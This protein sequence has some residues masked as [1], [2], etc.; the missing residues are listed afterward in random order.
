[1]DHLKTALSGAL[2]GVFTALMSLSFAVFAQPTQAQSY[3]LPMSPQVNDFAGML[4]DDTERV[5]ASQLLDLRRQTGIQMTVVTLSR[6]AMFAPDQT[7]EEFAKGLFNQW[8]IGD[9]TRNDG[10]LFLVLRSDREVRI[11]LGHGFQTEW[12]RAAAK[13][14]DDHVL[15]AFR[16]DNY[17]EGISGGVTA[18]INTIALPFSEGAE[19]PS[20]GWG[21][22]IAA[23][24]VGAPIALVMGLGALADKFRRCPQCGERGKLIVEKRTIKAATRNTTGKGEKTT[25]CSAC[26][27]HDI[28][29]Y[30]I[31]RS[32]SSSSSSGGFGGGSSGGGGAT[33]RW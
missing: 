1:M 8:G 5:I 27:Y 15:P 31:P 28:S 24:L 26:D 16:L 32:G 9:K 19:A 4:P 25:T 7:V 22:W 2:F 12:N 17:P 23:A 30:G 20:G 14:I 29:V 13:V 21:G 18:T 3:P 6:K 33:G 10:I 11:E